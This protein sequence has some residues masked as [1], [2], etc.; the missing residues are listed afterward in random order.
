MAVT[1][2]KEFHVAIVGK[3]NTSSLY[4]TALTH[5]AGAGIGG[6]ALAMALHKKGIS[7][8]LYEDAKEFSAVG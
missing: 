2:E 3:S 5:H 1:S 6:L 8:T 4:P 7:F